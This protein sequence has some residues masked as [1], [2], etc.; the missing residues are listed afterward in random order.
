MRDYFS[1]DYNAR[2]DKKLV[3][4]FM[5]FGLEGIG[6]YWCIIEM[7]YEE[8]GYLSLSE[9]ERITFEL[10]TTNDVIK[11]IV[12]DSEL[13]QNDGE[14]FWSNSVLERL[15]LRSIKSEKARKS[16]TSRWEKYERNTNII[17]TN[18][19]RNT[20]KV[21]DKVKV[22]ENIKEKK[23]FKPP[24]AEEVKTY[25]TEKGYT[26]DSSK[27]F[28]DYYTELG[29]HDSSGKKILN[30]KAKAQAVWFKDENRIKTDTK[31]KEITF[32]Y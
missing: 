13:I 6:A 14:K 29:W 18:E 4:L 5:K 8:N 19:K 17:L 31:I 21:K 3:N 2:N 28:F 1:H 10:R 12:F 27:R 11:Y 20:N 23:N 30:W 22:K 9:Y 26:V 16:I 25:F 15:K 32:N 24:T 7:L